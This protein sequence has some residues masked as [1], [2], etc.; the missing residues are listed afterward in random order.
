MENVIKKPSLDTLMW[1]VE[2]NKNDSI[3]E[4]AKKFLKWYGFAVTEKTLN[5]FKSRA[6]LTNFWFEHREYDWLGSVDMYRF[7][8]DVL[9]FLTLNGKNWSLE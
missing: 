4:A 9:S 7:C 3:D 2:I 6:Q 1:T 8:F 5:G